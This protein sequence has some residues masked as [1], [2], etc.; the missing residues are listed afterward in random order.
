MSSLPVL[1]SSF[2]GYRDLVLDGVSGILIPTLGPAE[3]RGTDALRCIVPDAEYPLLLAQQNVVDVESL[4][5]AMRLL[6]ADPEL[7]ARLGRAGRARALASYTWERVARSY[8]E[9]WEDLNREP[10]ALPEQPRERPARALFHPSEPPC[11]EIFQGY[12]SAASDSLAASG[13][14]VRWSQAG[15]AV[16]RGKDFPV[17]YRLLEERVDLEGLKKLLFLARRPVPAGELQKQAADILSD[18]P[19]DRDF[20]LLWALKHD[21]LEFVEE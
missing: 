9:L 19:T 10:C 12:F 4:G 2:N 3:T 14:K 7:R 18:V 11:M 13:R 15:A 5:R 20:L 1:A 8:L 21:F 16:Y 6:A 17:I